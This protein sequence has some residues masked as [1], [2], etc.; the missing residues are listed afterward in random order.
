MLDGGGQTVRDIWGKWEVIF[1]MG[2]EL[3]MD[4]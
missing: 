2:W 4:C 1:K 3:L